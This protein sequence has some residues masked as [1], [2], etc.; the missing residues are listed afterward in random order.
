MTREQSKSSDDTPDRP[1]RFLTRHE[2]LSRMRAD[3]RLTIISFFGLFT[4]LGILPFALYRFA[5]GDIVTGVGDCVL[6][7]VI[8]LLVIYAWRSGRTSLVGA[9]ASVVVMVGFIGLVTYTNISIFWAFPVLSASFLLTFRSFAVGVSVL[10]LAGIAVQ[11][12]QF[13]SGVELL[14]FLVTGVLVATFGLI[15]ASRTEM[16][17]RQLS[18]MAQRDPLTDA[19]NRR[20][21]RN[22]LDAVFSRYKNDGEPAS[23]AVL[24]LDHFKEVNDKHGHNAGDKVLVEVVR[25]INKYLR[26]QDRLYRLGGEEFVLVLPQT[27]RKG[28]EMVIAKLHDVLRSELRGP[29][30][31]VTVSIGAAELADDDPQRLFAR[32]DEALY[33]AKKRGR[34]RAEIADPD[35]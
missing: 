10:T 33:L 29:D 7:M 31:V 24:D 5:S 23:L 4:M 21:L 18:D 12:S 17:R 26:E 16:Q 2:L 3:F 35:P 25:L 28:L 19:G 14:S 32:A 22:K 8:G 6:I 13:E 9:L 30:G 34:D 15:F 20:A 27:D 11:P 1:W